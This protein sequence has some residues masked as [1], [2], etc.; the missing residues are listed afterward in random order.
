MSWGCCSRGPKPLA[1]N[2]RSF[3]P[4]LLGTVIF[5][6]S[7]LKVLRLDPLQEKRFFSWS[8]DLFSKCNACRSPHF[9]R[10]ISLEEF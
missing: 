5:L 6:V 4:I 1:L 2:Q 3:F 9:G 10:H 7:T 8:C